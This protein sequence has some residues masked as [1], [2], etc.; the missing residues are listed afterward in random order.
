MVFVNA[1]FHLAPLSLFIY[2]HLFKEGLF[3]NFGI[4]ISNGRCGFEYL[5][6]LKDYY[7]MMECYDIFEY[8]HN[9]Y[10]LLLCIFFKKFPSGISTIYFVNPSVA[11]PFYLGGAWGHQPVGRGPAAPRRRGGGR[12]VA[13]ESVT[14][15]WHEAGRI[16]DPQSNDPNWHHQSYSPET[17]AVVR[18]FALLPGQFKT[19]QFPQIGI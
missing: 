3:I 4:L 13:A 15:P 9:V 12:A 5:I 18:C 8:Q 19:T 6:F 16:C 14:S 17:A 11:Y 2:L 1:I 10:V 7:H